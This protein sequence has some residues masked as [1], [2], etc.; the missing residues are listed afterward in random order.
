MMKE[1]YDELVTIILKSLVTWVL[2][3]AVILGVSWGISV[4]AEL[5]TK[6]QDKWHQYQDSEC[7][8]F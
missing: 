1:F 8:W 5:P 2:V 3:I 7:G 4:A 6:I